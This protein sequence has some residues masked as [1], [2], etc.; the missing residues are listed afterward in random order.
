MPS[1]QGD[2][3]SR[4]YEM[5]RHEA[6]EYDRDFIKKYEE[7]LDTTLIFVRVFFTFLTWMR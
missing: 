3:R 4:F 2:Y 1:T 5:Y 6:E 7:D